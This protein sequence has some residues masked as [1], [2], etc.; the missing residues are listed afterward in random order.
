MT[1]TARALG[2]ILAGQLGLAILLA[3]AYPWLALAA[4]ALFGVTAFVY[5]RLPDSR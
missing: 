5:V 1:R 3:D 2:W 4:I